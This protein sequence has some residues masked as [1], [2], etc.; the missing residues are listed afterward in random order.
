VHQR[1][2]PPAG[3]SETSTI[4]VEELC[5]K[6]PCAP[7][8]AYEEPREKRQRE[9]DGGPYRGEAQPITDWPWTLRR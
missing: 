3:S 6:P 2:K 5:R 4:E 9:P 8:V 1:G 7:G